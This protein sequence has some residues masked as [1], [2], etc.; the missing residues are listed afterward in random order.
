MERALINTLGDCEHAHLAKDKSWLCQ[1]PKNY[2]KPAA[3]SGGSF[4]CLF[5][6]GGV[7][8]RCYHV[9]LAVL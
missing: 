1:R 4:V 7:E 3:M 5:V 8:A 9:A 6:F 2:P